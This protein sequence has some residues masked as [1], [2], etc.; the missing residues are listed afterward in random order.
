MAKELE[1]EI[2]VCPGHQEYITPLI[3][4]FAFNGAEIWCPYC[5]QTYGGFSADDIEN[6]RALQKR[7]DQYQKYT[8]EGDDAYLHAMAVLVCSGTE[9]KGETIKPNELPK[10]EQ[11]RLE[12]IRKAWSYGR[13]IEDILKKK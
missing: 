7:H 8:Q 11:K 12:K 9:W 4:T 3:W 10:T 2:E 5:G 6:T 1:K 13:K